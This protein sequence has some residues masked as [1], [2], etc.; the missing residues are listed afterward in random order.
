MTSRWANINK[1][2]VEQAAVILSAAVSLKV[3]Y[4]TTSVNDLEWI[5]WPTKTVVEQITATRFHFES[6]SGYMSE[7]RSFLIAA[8]CSGVNFLIAVFLMFSLRSLW[9]HRRTAISWFWMVWFAAISYL[10][11][12]VANSLRISS[13]LWLI[14]APRKF[15]GLDRDELHRL[16]GIFIYFG[17]MLIVYVAYE[18]IFA[19]DRKLRWHSF[20]FPLAIYYAITLAIPVANG[21][22]QVRGFL[23]HAFFVLIMPI[24]LIGIV[25]A[26]R[27]FLFRNAEREFIPAAGL[28]FPGNLGVDEIC[29]RANV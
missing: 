9:S 24:M 25:I 17:M 12:I 4:S 20:L 13:A 27:Q 7:D 5:L 22:F 2:T 6:Y 15:F 1:K 26:S 8:S 14:S 18:L 19:R 23:T 11:T 16:D 28:S 21:A 10:I 29:P 3:F